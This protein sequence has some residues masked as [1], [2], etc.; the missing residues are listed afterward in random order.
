MS[1]INPTLNFELGFYFSEHFSSRVAYFQIFLE[2]KRGFNPQNPPMRSLL[3]I[4]NVYIIN[5]QIK[6]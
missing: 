4:S 3:L 1:D 2:F 5:I 6:K